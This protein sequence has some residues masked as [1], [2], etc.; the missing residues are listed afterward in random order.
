MANGL[1]PLNSF[2]QQ[3]DPDGDGFTNLQEFRFG[4]DPNVADLDENNNGV[5]DSVDLR[6]M[7]TIVPYIVLPLLLEGGVISD[8]FND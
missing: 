1:D 5:P 4:T 8:D 3:G 6:R 2:D 7:R